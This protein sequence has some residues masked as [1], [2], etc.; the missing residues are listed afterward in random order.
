[1]T[2][3]TKKVGSISPNATPGNPRHYVNTGWTGTDS[4]VLVTTPHPK[5][6]P[7]GVF[8]RSSRWMQVTPDPEPPRTVNVFGVVAEALRLR[9]LQESSL[10]RKL[11]ELPR[12]PGWKP[13]RLPKRARLSE[14]PYYKWWVTL[15]ST[16]HQWVE[17]LIRVPCQPVDLA[18]RYNDMMDW[19]GLTSVDP[20]IPWDA[21]DQIK[22]IN[23]MRDKVYGS[24]FDPSV[25][26]GESH[27]ALGLIANS[28][29]RIA[30][31]LTALKRGDFIGAASALRPSTGRNPEFI[32]ADR[33]RA[34]SGQ[35]K[36]LARGSV[37]DRMSSQTGFS[38]ETIVTV[39][40]ALDTGQP[41]PPG[42]ARRGFI[43]AR[44]EARRKVELH[45]SAKKEFSSLWLELQY[46][47][48]PLLSD[49]EE[50]AQFLAHQLNS[51]LQ[52]TYRAS[53]TKREVLPKRET[54]W[55]R[56][57]G[58]GRGTGKGTRLHRVSLIARFKEKP[59]LPKL[60][61]LLSLESVAWE[62]TPWSF[63]VDWFIPIGDWLTARGFSQ[64]L[65]GTF[66]TTTKAVGRANEP[67]GDFTIPFSE[68]TPWERNLY[69]DG[70]VN[71]VIS[72]TLPVP[73]PTT[74]PLNKA[75][76]WRHC[77]NAVALLVSGHGGQGYK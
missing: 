4:L 16:T 5:W 55:Q 29:R 53:Y 51:P 24:Q 28:A 39:M 10:E 30:A 73:A 35:A 9:D 31:S 57:P 38:R 76:S 49:A 40:R 68:I 70:Y 14:N 52:T 26:L 2:T 46:G 64:G 54:Q 8:R 7:K 19:R 44:R 62:L 75:L 56:C 33:L 43:D 50:G 63:V 47:W 58:F 60:L 41:L 67:T 15:N 77:V 34:L 48:L 71:R 61:G 20:Q 3:G 17:Q 32:R 23:R 6:D 65:T 25:F 13:S 72:T 1:M 11:R 59:N 74:K 27:Q 42:L 22:L 21:N 66:I 36:A 69:E 12:S 45:V 18:V 37:V